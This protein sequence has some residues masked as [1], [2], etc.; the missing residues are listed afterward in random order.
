[1]R[2]GTPIL[3]R[4]T[5]KLVLFITLTLFAFLISSPSL[6]SYRELS[7]RTKVEIMHKLCHWRLELDDIGDLLRVSD[8]LIYMYLCICI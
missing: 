2:N 4:S 6:S 7:T 3:T 1:M 8:K 5:S